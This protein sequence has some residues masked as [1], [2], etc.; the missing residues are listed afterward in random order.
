VRG[1]PSDAD[2]TGHVLVDPQPLALCVEQVT[3]VQRLCIAYTMT[4]N[5]TCMSKDPLPL[6]CIG[7]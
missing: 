1:D 3:Q 5:D 4:G 6:R 2:A 7:G